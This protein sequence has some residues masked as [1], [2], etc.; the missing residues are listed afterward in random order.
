MSEFLAVLAVF[1]MCNASAEVRVLSAGEAVACNGAFEMVK[2]HFARA[3]PPGTSRSSKPNVHDTGAY[4]AF[5]RWEIDNAEL[6][7][8]MQR[9]ARFELRETPVSHSMP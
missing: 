1:Y 8:E 9:E 5:K 4:L 6:V 3:P 7:E 2:A